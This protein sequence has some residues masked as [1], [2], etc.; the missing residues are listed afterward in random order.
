MQDAYVHGYNG[1]ETVRLKDQAEAL[2]DL[3]HGDTAYSEGTTVHEAGCGVGAQTV[4][5]ARNSPKAAITSIDISRESLAQA[6]SATHA[7][8]ITNVSFLEADIFDLPFAIE[9]FDHIFIC[10]VLEHVNRPAQASRSLGRVLKAGGTLTVI[11]GTR[12][13]R[14]A[15]I[16]SRNSNAGTCWG[17]ATKH[18]CKMRK[19]VACTLSTICHSR[20]NARTSTAFTKAH[21]THAFGESMSIFAAQTDFRL[22]P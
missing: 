12:I 21:A 15:A 22:K 1:R 10:F 18:G 4:T 6:E 8:G 17:N 3:L 9:S 11:E 7:A 19:G 2:T 14:S 13:R 5:L 20:T 16:Q